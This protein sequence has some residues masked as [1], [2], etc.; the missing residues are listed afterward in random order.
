MPFI[1]IEKLTHTYES[2]GDSPVVA[3][4]GID[5]DIKE[6]EFI[7]FI[8]ANGSGKSTLALHLNAILLP[9][10]G[11]VLV[12]GRDTT[13][14]SVTRTIRA[15]VGMVFQSPQD[16]F[17]A[18]VVEEDV[19]FGPENLAVSEEEL[20][21]RVESALRRVGMWEERKRP[22]LQ[23]SAGQQQRVAIAG[24]LAM[25]PRCLIL[26]EATAMLDP[27]GSGELLD[28]LDDL[29]TAGMTVINITHQME[30]AARSDR[31][32]VLH[33]GR[34]E[35][36]GSPSEVF[37]SN[38]LS[39]YGLTPP[40]ASQLASRLRKSF[41]KLPRGLLTISDLAEELSLLSGE[42]R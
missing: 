37:S 21:L 36:D 31:I 3:L 25:R 29:H 17:V 28:I 19:A 10:A 26:D 1:R 23:L 18:T 35:E 32:I 24:A 13:D 38:A 7:S 39:T 5:L 9:T 15:D 33:N 6:G 40:R 4:S 12:D 22:P 34:I 27:A 11:R 8:G 2:N 20:P 16:Q 42:A 30:E 41:R 14:G